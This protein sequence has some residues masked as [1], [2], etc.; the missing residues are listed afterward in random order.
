MWYHPPWSST[1]F[2]VVA[3]KRL[4]T[5]C[6]SQ[7][8]APRVEIGLHGRHICDLKFTG[9]IRT[10][11]KDIRGHK[12]WLI[13]PLSAYSFPNPS[14]LFPAASCYTELWSP[15]DPVSLLWKQRDKSPSSPASEHLQLLFHCGFWSGGLTSSEFEVW[16]LSPRECHFCSLFCPWI[17]HR[18]YSRASLLPQLPTQDPGL[19]VQWR[20]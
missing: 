5:L 6:K 16:C 12:G 2:T 3:S 11:G 9:H 18:S 10:R 1:L 8:Y 17:V 19:M 20:L 4:W 7:I 14:L 15:G 13:F